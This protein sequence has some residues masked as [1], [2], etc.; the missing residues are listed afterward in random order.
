MKKLAVLVLVLGGLVACGEP[1]IEAQNADTIEAYEKYLAENPDG[2]FALEASGRLETLYLE[3][4]KTEKT[5]EAYDAYLERFPEGA[6]RD[7]A[8]TERE[9]FLYDWA[10]QTNTAE[11]WQKY[12]DEYPKGKKQRRQYAKRMLTVHAYLP[13]LDVGPADKQQVN[14]A[15]DPEGPL[16]G[17]GFTTDVTNNGDKTVIDLRLT[18]QYLSPEG[19]VLEEKEWPVVAEYWPVP[20][21]EERKVAMQPGET[22]TWEWTTGNLPERWDRQVRVYVSRVVLEGQNSKEDAD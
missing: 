11:G 19:G 6:M 10:K 22:R 1:F 12:L 8:L 20:V 17:W 2:R 4:A 5:L 3:R 13:S 7:K 14:L 16:D 21:E 15:E 9:E 18:I